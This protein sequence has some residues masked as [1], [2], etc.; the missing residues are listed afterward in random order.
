MNFR[1]SYIFSPQELNLCTLLLFGVCGTRR[2]H[3][4][5]TSDERQLNGEGQ[6]SHYNNR[7]VACLRLR[8]HSAA[9]PVVRYLKKKIRSFGPLANYAD[10][11][12][13][14]SWRG[15]ANFCG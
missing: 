1:T 4:D 6:I 10:R 13:A 11:A 8:A 7:K 2:G 15:S 14:T 12:T 3:V 5:A 9:G